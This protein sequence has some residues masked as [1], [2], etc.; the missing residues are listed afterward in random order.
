VLVGPTGEAVGDDSTQA[1][2]ISAPKVTT[3][4]RLVIEMRDLLLYITQLEISIVFLLLDCSFILP[5]ISCRTI[6]L[7]LHDR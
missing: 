7:G 2:R 4:I 5:S 3:S 6:L 1:D